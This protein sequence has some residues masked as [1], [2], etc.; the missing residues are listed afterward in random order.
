MTNRKRCSMIDAIRRKECPHY[1]AGTL[2]TDCRGYEMAV[3][4]YRKADGSVVTIYHCR[5][6]PPPPLQEEL[7]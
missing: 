4:S 7:L 3:T 5:Y 1:S 6:D 2:A